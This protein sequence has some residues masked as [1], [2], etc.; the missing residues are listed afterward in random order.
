VNSTLALEIPFL[1][2]KAQY[3]ALAPEINRAVTSVLESAQ[4]VGGALVE[5]FE[6]EFATYIGAKHA[7]GV[8]SGTSALELAL[9]VAGIGPGD[10]VLVPANSFFA[11]A[12][13]VSNVGAK[14]VF[15][16]VDAASCHLDVN[17]AERMITSRTR[18]IIPVHLYGRAMDLR[19]VAEFAAA[20]RLQ[21]IE[22][23]A[24][25]HGSAR[26]GVRV[27]AAGRL[28]CFSFY[29]GKNLGAYGDAGAV[30]TNDSDEARKLRL[31]RDHGSPAKYQHSVI[32]TNARLDSIQAAI[33]SIKLRHLDQ[34]N[35]LRRK[36]AAQMA[37][38]LADSPVIPPEVPAGGEHVFHLFVVR[39]PQRN[40]LR[41]YLSANGIA[42]GIHYP[43]PLHL[44]EAY[45]QLGYPEKGSLPT[46]EQL[47]ED[48]LS[49]PMYAELTD[50]QI[51]YTIDAVL[52]FAG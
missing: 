29:P 5:N 11:T 18:A 21:I 48:I 37:S 15:T 25:A 1:D 40:A 51:E 31:L 9:K 44:T 36:H 7:V 41:S 50:E 16:D 19:R 52:N 47:S 32:G 14:P 10:E 26:N 4:F 13:A 27:G 23:A 34:W 30:T 28:T 33:L 2:L 17:S 45:Q 39:T 42:T 46:A 43:V 22:D 20:Y 6:H 12:E 49:L 24:Q 8:S 3:R 38:A 35:Q